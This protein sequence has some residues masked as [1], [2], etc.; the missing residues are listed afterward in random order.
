MAVQ[1]VP[2]VADHRHAVIDIFNH[3]VES[4]FAAYPEKPVPYEFFD[5]ML[6]ACAG[7]PA[8]AA[9][10]EAGQVLG[11]GMLRPYHPMAAFA[12]TAEISYFLKTGFTGRGIGR[13]ILDHLLAGARN[14]GLSMILAS[15]SSRNEGSIRFHAKNGFTECGRFRCIGRKNGQA[16]DVVWMQRML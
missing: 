8:V 11:F 7:Y 3:Y 1:L 9:C 5:M 16:F 14:K 15:I 12:Q 4:T 13:Q 6:K 10:D 2:M